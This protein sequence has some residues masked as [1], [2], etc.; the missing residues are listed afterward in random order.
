MD[1]YYTDKE[2]IIHQINRRKFIYNKEYIQKRFDTY[3][4]NCIKI[5]YLRLGYILGSCNIIPSSIL[6][7][8]YGNGSFLKI[9]T[10]I[11]S[12]CYG[13][14]ISGYKL[15]NNCTFVSDIFDNYYDVITFFDSLEH[16]EDISF[17]GDLSCKYICVSVPWCRDNTDEYLSNWKHLRP[18]E[19]LHHFND[20][21][22]I[23]FFK[24]HGYSNI[25]QSNVEDIIRKSNTE[26]NILT[27]IFKKI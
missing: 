25:A 20:K 15:P 18:D 26:K 7:V 24:K 12:N 10:N 4:D 1:N 16:Y 22:I 8:G 3:I 23:A 13:H 17:I 27:S 19:H 5:S 9:C 2:G 11:I 14:D 6:D 21:S